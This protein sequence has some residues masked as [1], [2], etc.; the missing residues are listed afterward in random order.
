MYSETTPYQFYFEE[1]L[2]YITFDAVKEPL[3]IYKLT[4]ETA[5]EQKV[6]KDYLNDLLK[7]YPNNNLTN[8]SYRFEAERS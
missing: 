8:S 4:V 1:G 3:V 7:T 2:N 5:V 6:Y